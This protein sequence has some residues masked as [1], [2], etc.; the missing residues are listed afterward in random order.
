MSKRILFYSTFLIFILSIII[1]ITFRINAPTHAQNSCDIT[2]TEDSRHINAREAPYNQIKPGD[3]VCIAAG[4]YTTIRFENFHGSATDPITFINTSGQVIFN[5][6]SDFAFVFRNSKFFH[7]TGTGS[8]SHLYGFKINGDYTAGLKIT[9]KSEEFE[10]DHFEISSI[11]IGVSASTKATCP[12]GSENNYDYD[13]DGI[14]KNDPDDSVDWTTFTQHNSELHDFIIH[15]TETEGFYIGSNDTD[16][17]NTARNSNC[18]VY[19]SHLDGVK[20]YDNVVERSGWEGI[21]VKGSDGNCQVFNNKI[22]NAV[23]PE[24]LQASG[25]NSAIGINHSQCDAYNNFIK[26]S[27]GRGINYYRRRGPIN[28]YN[29]IIVNTGLH[30][31]I[32]ISNASSIRIPQAL[33]TGTIQIYNNTLIEPRG[34][35]VYIRDGTDG[36]IKNNIIINSNSYYTNVYSNIVESNNLELNTISQAKFAS[37]GNEDYSLQSDSPAIDTGI[38]VSHSGIEYDFLNNQ[39]PA[40][41]DGNGTAEYDIGAYEYIGNIPVPLPPD[42]DYEIMKVEHAPVIDGY[43]YEFQDTPSIELDQST[44]NSHGSYRLLYDDTA[45]YIAAEVT[46]SQLMS[47]YSNPQTDRDQ[48]LWEDDSIELMLD[49]LHNGGSSRQS[50]DYKLF[51]NLFNVHTDSNAGD[52][53]WPID[54]TDFLSA[55]KT[56]GSIND[57]S[58]TDLGYTIEMKIPWSYLGITAPSANTTFGLEIVLDDRATSSADP[59]GTRFYTAWKNTDGNNLNNPDGWGSA[60][61]SSSSVSGRSAYD[62]NTDGFV[63]TLDAKQEIGS[64]NDLDFPK[65]DF[66]DDGVVNNLDTARIIYVLLNP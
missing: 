66:N 30:Y 9:N 29:N 57:N 33:T 21:N 61:F 38:Y 53:S 3:T 48:R 64:W 60:I 23:E 45:L 10:A 7:V 24:A 19:N 15:D 47:Q 28:I 25:Q 12:D 5:G 34:W 42:T 26:D 31:P 13:G 46:D 27:G 4:N 50:D 44:T 59:D 36:F 6:V 62:L 2:I 11:K 40:D 43:L 18:P 37:P 8:E 14:I 65:G 56:Y 32:G 17:P 49:T 52:Q 63:D 20:I 54:G 35:G 16:S 58:D 39:R 1:I 55:I 22:Y 51:V 41:G